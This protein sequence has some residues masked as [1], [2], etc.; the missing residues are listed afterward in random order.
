M[1]RQSR[2]G[3]LLAVTA[4]VLLAGC[5][6]GTLSF[7]ATPATIPPASLT[8]EGYVAGNATA[9]PLRLPVGVAGVGTTVDVT[10]HVAGYSRTTASND[11]A[12]LLLLSTPDERVAGRS[13]NP[14]A[15]ATNRE[16]LQ[17]ALT[18]LERTGGLAGEYT[19]AGTAGI[20]DLREVAVRNVTMFGEPTELTTYAGTATADGERVAVLVHVAAVRHDGD[21]VV[22]LAVHGESMDERDAVARLVA[23]AEH[24]GAEVQS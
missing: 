23:A 9:V 1:S 19:P 11:T 2:V 22:A 18:T 4:V 14:F 24:D 21:V 3:P 16:V 8:A 20:A 7:S 17:T 15:V 6:G 12:G 13:V 5:L 10:A